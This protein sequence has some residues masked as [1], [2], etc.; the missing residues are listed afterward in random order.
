MG[1][2]S[3]HVE[4]KTAS[5]KLYAGDGT[6]DAY[7]IVAFKFKTKVPDGTGTYTVTATASMSG[8][9]PGSGSTTFEVT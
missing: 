9:D 2:A 8:Y 3:V 6:T 5:G 7:G 4:V 1:G